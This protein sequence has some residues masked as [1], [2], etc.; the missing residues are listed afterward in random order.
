[1]QLLKMIG[2]LRAEKLIERFTDDPVSGGM[3]VRVNGRWRS[4][5]KEVSIKCQFCY[6]FEH[7]HFMLYHVISCVIGLFRLTFN[8]VGGGGH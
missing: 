7:G 2:V 5:E 1:M 8:K 6:L 3:K 4:I